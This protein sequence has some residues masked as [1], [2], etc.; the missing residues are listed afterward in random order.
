MLYI[1]FSRYCLNTDVFSMSTN[2]M[3]PIDST[4]LFLCRYHKINIFAG[5]L[6]HIGIGKEKQ[7]EYFEKL[8]P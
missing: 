2:V 8:C 5:G 3:I 7:G 6:W 1:K 4:S